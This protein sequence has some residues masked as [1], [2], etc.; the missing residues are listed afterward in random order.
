MPKILKDQLRSQDLVSHKC[1]SMAQPSKLM[2]SMQSKYLTYLVKHAT[3]ETMTIKIFDRSALILRFRRFCPMHGHHSC[4]SRTGVMVF[5]RAGCEFILLLAAWAFHGVDCA[6]RG[7]ARTVAHAKRQYS[8]TSITPF[9]FVLLL[10]P[11][12]P[13]GLGRRE[14]HMNDQ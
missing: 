13:P 6:P 14:L 11:E 1:L 3:E 5:S 2:L 12:I 9:T 4:Q 7:K 10:G 8:A